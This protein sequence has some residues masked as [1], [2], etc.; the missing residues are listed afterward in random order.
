MPL[1]QLRGEGW[2]PAPRMIFARY[3]HVAACLDGPHLC[4]AGGVLNG[5]IE[6]TSAEVLPI[7]NCTPVEM[8][9]TP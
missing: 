9:H 3:G 1:W 8:L 5:A 6:T 7:G 2:Q 4:V